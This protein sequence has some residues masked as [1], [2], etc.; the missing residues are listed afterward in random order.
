M[1]TP[2]P[3]IERACPGKLGQASHVK[4]STAAFWK[5]GRPVPTSASGTLLPLVCRIR[6]AATSLE[7]T[8]A[9]QWERALGWAA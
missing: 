4:R 5:L 3:S 8:P 7:P 1:E 6:M 2:N 9:L